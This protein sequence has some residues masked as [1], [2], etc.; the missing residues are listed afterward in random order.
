M[1]VVQM[2]LLWLKKIFITNSKHATYS[3]ANVSIF[4]L[5][6]FKILQLFFCERSRLLDLLIKVV[7]LRTIGLLEKCHVEHFVKL[8]VFSDQFL[9]AS[10]ALLAFMFTYV[11][12]GL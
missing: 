11:Y 3:N 8:P 10:V 6:L 4:K 9:N 2:M 5:N 12:M 7:W 1:S